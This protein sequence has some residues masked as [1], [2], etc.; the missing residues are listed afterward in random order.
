MVESVNGSIPSVNKFSAT[1]GGGFY[2]PTADQSLTDDTASG[3]N[4]EVGAASS[5]GWRWFLGP[6]FGTV[7]AHL[8]PTGV[9]SV[10]H[11]IIAPFFIGNLTTPSTSSAACTAGQFEDDATYH[12]VCTATNTWKRITLVAF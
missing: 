1:A 9:F 5:Y 11:S 10:Y 12:Y 3:W 2:G 8:D 4:F 7:L 6:T